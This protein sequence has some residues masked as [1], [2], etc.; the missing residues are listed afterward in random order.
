MLQRHTVQRD[1]GNFLGVDLGGGKGKTTAVARLGRGEGGVLEVAEVG[2]SRDGREP[3]HD[4]PLVDYLGGFAGR[5]VVAIDAPLNLPACV[6]CVE[7]TC[8]GARACVDPTVVWF[9]TV[10]DR[11]IAS[12]AAAD[13]DRIAT[14]AGPGKGGAGPNGTSK[15]GTTPY[16]QRASEVILHRRHGI[17][18][19]ETLGQGMGPLT[20]RAARLVRELSRFGYR[21]HEDLIEVYPKAT[22]H[23][24]WGAKVA[25][26]YKRE[27]GTWE[28]RA[29]VLE[30]LR[31][32][33]AFAPTSG[34]AREQVL[35]ND[36]CFDAVVCAYTAALWARE[37]WTLP[38]TDR[39]VFLAD[40]W[41]YVPGVG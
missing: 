21:L 30:S 22:I 25:R 27:V 29:Q 8:P 41:I 18:A 3:W 39:A 32:S 28:T 37:G 36:H 17:L 31:G 1:L 24:L 40:G 16:T 5:A 4:E 11:L 23:Q 13:R 14:V 2:T 7:P 10:G 38:A 34:L 33:L 20:A 26:R 19:R 6:R 35:Q 15:P 9:R 12:A